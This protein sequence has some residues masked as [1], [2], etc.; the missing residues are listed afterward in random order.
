MPQDIIRI[1][2]V[3]GG[4]CSGPLEARTPTVSPS[5]ELSD[6]WA[7]EGSE[8]CH[9]RANRTFR[10]RYP[11]AGTSPIGIRANESVAGPAAKQCFAA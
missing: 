9:G 5:T 3:A 8:V 7:P 4:A 2:L 11:Q 1:G 6:E 10:A